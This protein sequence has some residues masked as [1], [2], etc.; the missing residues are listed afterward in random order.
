MTYVV[1]SRTQEQRAEQLAVGRCPRCQN[2]I[3]MEHVHRRW[4]ASAESWLLPST[5]WRCRECGFEHAEALACEHCP[6]G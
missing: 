3:A 4:D 1:I 5:S 6:T 2:T